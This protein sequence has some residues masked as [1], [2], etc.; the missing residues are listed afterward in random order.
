MLILKYFQLILIYSAV[1]EWMTVFSMVHRQELISPISSVLPSFSPSA[2]ASPSCDQRSKLC[3]L[4]EAST[5]PSSAFSRKKRTV[6]PSSTSISHS[7]KEP[8]ISAKQLPSDTMTTTASSSQSLS[9]PPSHTPVRTSSASF[10]STTIPLRSETISSTPTNSYII[11]S[12]LTG[13]PSKSKKYIVSKTRSPSHD[14]SPSASSTLSSSDGILMF[15]S[16]PTISPTESNSFALTVNGSKSTPTNTPY[17][18]TSTSISSTPFYSSIQPSVSESPSPF[19]K[20]FISSI[21][22]LPVFDENDSIEV[23]SENL[24]LTFEFLVYT[25]LIEKRKSA[26]VR[27]TVKIVESKLDQFN[28]ASRRLEFRSSTPITNASK[29]S[30]FAISNTNTKA[31]QTSNRSIITVCQVSRCATRVYITSNKK[32]KHRIVTKALKKLTKRPGF[33]QIYET[34]RWKYIV[35]RFGNKRYM[36]DI[37]FKWSSN[38]DV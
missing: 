16:P 27:S 37:P 38:N 11:N 19:G 12:K 14:S 33:R 1:T 23:L 20:P 9:I 28:G 36:V 34:K 29:Q 35:R 26:L 17:S 30:K 6:T 8:T 4:V 32:I 2:R 15:P 31:I 13:S 22:E 3:A 24:K 7:S 5:S 25:F 10:Q 18:T 21:N